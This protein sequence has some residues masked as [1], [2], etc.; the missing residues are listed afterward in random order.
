[1][2]KLR[3]GYARSSRLV[4]RGHILCI[5]RTRGGTY[6]IAS[7]RARNR[8]RWDFGISSY[9]YIARYMSVDRVA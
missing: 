8:K 4:V 7:E 3:C 6:H 1:M 2:E 5:A 9:T